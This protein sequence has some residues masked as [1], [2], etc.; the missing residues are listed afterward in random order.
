MGLFHNYQIPTNGLKLF[1]DETLNPLGTSTGFQ[2]ISYGDNP[3]SGTFSVPPT[4]VEWARNIT[5]I[6]V[7]V[8]VYKYATSVGYATHPIN[9]WGTGGSGLETAGLVLYNFGNYQGNGEDG[10]MAFYMGDFNGSV[11]GWRGHGVAGGSSKIQVGEYYHVVFQLGGGIGWTWRNGQKVEQQSYPRPI[12]NST[13][14][15]YGQNNFNI[16]GPY[17]Q[18]FGVIKSGLFY[19]RTCSD[20]EILTQLNYFKRRYPISNR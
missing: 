17:Q 19:N 15:G 6:T 11:G 3:Y 18:D 12:A 5:N 16:Y 13:I 1:V 2:G 8:V 9:M 7:S 4:S 14:A 10:S 20:E